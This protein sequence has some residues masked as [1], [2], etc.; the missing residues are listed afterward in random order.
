M[1]QEKRATHD[2]E[3]DVPKGDG[4]AHIEALVHERS[5]DD[6]S[7]VDHRADDDRA[8]EAKGRNADKFEKKYWL[9]VNYIGT[10]FAIGMAFMGGIGGKQPIC[11]FAQFT[12]ANISTRVWSDCASTRRDQCRHRSFA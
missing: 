10:L 8:D 12:R 2:S 9:S 7:Y 6:P 4:I 11:N 1:A 3:S 5:N